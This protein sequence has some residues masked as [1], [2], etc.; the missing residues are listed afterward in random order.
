MTVAPSLEAANDFI[1]FFTK[2]VE[3]FKGSH[4]EPNQ[5]DDDGPPL[6]K[7]R[8]AINAARELATP[9]PWAKRSRT[10]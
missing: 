1:K 2:E 10:E 4:A 9:E 7:Q 6:K 3:I 5:L 8:E